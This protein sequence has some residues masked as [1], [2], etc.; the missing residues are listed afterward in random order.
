MDLA[1]IGLPEF[2]TDYPGMDI[3][4]SRGGGVLLRGDFEFS[5]KS[6]SGPQVDDSFRIEILVPERFPH[7][8]PSVWERGGR[9]PQTRNGEYHVNQSGTLCL[10][11]PLRLVRNVFHKP[12][13]S[14]F[15]ESSV[16][17]FLYAVSRKL[18]EGGRFFMG[19]L[20][21]GEPGV[22]EDYRNLFGLAE[23]GQ[24][25]Q[26]L[27]L[28]GLKKRVANKCPCPCGCG[29]RFG[30][31]AK[32]IHLNSFRKLAPRAWFRRHAEKP[33]AGVSA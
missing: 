29:F 31:C 19:E 9:I 25:V 13:L 3:V 26:A 30:T 24:I 21:H 6:P 18:K 1:A 22:I 12:T 4:P 32:H 8:V 15:A 23:R 33:G 14:G 2:L 28:L 16:V 5:C 10:G 11:S 7:A 27:R 17:P 20:E